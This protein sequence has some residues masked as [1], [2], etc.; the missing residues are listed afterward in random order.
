[1]RELILAI[2]LGATKILTG[3]M[4]MDGTILGQSRLPTPAAVPDI[5][6]NTMVNSARKLAH[7]CRVKEEEITGIAIAT[8]GPLAYPGGI[9]RDSPN[10]GWGEVEL[11]KEMSR[12]FGRPVIVEKDTNMAALGEY[13]Y[14]SCANCQE[15]LYITISSGIG[16][17]MITS[18]RLNRG[19][20][21][22]A[23]EFGHMVIDTAGP[24]CN[25]G[26]RGCMEALASGIAISRQMEEL[27]AQGN[28]QAIIRCTHPGEKPGARELGRAAREGDPEAGSIIAQLAEYL[29]I[30]IANMVNILNPQAIIL[31]G[32]VMLGLK[33]LLFPLL[34]EYVFQHAFALNREK[35]R[36]ECTAL[37]DAVVLY[38]CL[39]A[40]R[41]QKIKRGNKD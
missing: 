10:L 33:D 9:V 4:G 29:G 35:L 8:P 27:I 5:I 25:C 3:I 36:I 22:G 24:R 32:G 41:E 18:G 31:G 40:V 37:G 20:S 26:R 19:I 39:A 30:G 2:D 12:L 28:G 6:M 38:G 15:L 17:G 34:K 14:G 1:M 16:A 23:G 21:G 7:D 13:H 11:E